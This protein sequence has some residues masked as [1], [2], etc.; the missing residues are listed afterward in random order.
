MMTYYQYLNV[1]ITSAMNREIVQK[2]K[3]ARENGYEMFKEC[4]LRSGQSSL[5]NFLDKVEK[6]E[7]VDLETL[8]QGVEMELKTRERKGNLSFEN[9]IFQ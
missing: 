3:S 2:V 4:L 8:H 7:D 1:K 9:H 5:C 6:G